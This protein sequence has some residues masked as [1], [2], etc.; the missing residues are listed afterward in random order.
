MDNTR[1]EMRKLID[2]IEKGAR[3]ASVAQVIDDMK[4]FSN[5][6]SF[7]ANMLDTRLK[8]KGAKPKMRSK[9]R[10]TVGAPRPPKPSIPKSS[11]ASRQQDTT[12]GMPNAIST[13]ISQADYD[14]LKPQT[15]RVP[16]GGVK[17]QRT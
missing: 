2:V 10:K 17:T 9:L 11:S 12:T 13:A 4:T 1:D 15:A 7:L 14:R 6:A 8:K 3:S 16:L 5:T